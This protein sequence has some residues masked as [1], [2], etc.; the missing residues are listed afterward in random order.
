MSEQGDLL[1][2]PDDAVSLV[3]G[4]A[5]ADIPEDKW[6]QLLADLLSV[7]EALFRKRG[8][9]AAAAFE[10]AAASVIAIGEYLGG[11]VA[12]IPRGD[13][14]IKAVRDA[15]IWRKFDGRPETVCRLADEHK[16]TV[17]SVYA[18]LKAQRALHVRKLQGR[19]FDD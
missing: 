12:Y 7:L 18:I 13:R 3:A 4:A 19:L 6:P 9:E 2:M 11:R 14:L 1:G 10:L 5:L 8:F 15:Q 17:V 16:L